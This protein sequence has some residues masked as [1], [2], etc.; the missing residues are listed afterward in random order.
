MYI[1]L[2][3]YSRCFPHFSTMPHPAAGRD[4]RT[5]CLHRPWWW[6]SLGSCS[7]SHLVWPWARRVQRCTLLAAGRTC[8]GETRMAIL[9]LKIRHAIDLGHLIDWWY[10]AIQMWCIG[11]NCRTFRT[12]AIHTIAY[13]YRTHFKANH[14]SHHLFQPIV[15]NRRNCQPDNWSVLSFQ[16]G[17][18]SSK[19]KYWYT[20]ILR[21]TIY[22]YRLTPHQNLGGFAASISFPS[23]SAIHSFSATSRRQVC[24][25][26][27]ARYSNESR[28]RELLSVA[29]AAGVSVAFGAP[30]GGVLF[31]YEEVSTRRLGG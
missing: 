30:V 22:N 13:V 9:N 27:S 5:P 4:L 6:R 28:F 19:K 8:L 15:V 1:I 24:S 20:T 2:A 18:S 16:S 3:T 14:S 26:F 29:S 21:R 7:R 10:I 23:A 12:P 31:S 17:H 11:S 25:G